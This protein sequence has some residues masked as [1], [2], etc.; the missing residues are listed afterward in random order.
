MYVKSVIEEMFMINYNTSFIVNTP[1]QHNKTRLY[2][3]PHYF[4]PFI[5][6]FVAYI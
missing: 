3:L 5:L 6:R 1:H 2:I 4:E